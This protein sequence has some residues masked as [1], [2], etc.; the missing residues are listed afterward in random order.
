MPRIARFLLTAALVACGGSN[1]APEAQ[2]TA[3]AEPTATDP[4]ATTA[5]MRI[6]KDFIFLVRCNTTRGQHA[7]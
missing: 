6:A 5:S 7:A 4:T 2:A 3:P 1:P